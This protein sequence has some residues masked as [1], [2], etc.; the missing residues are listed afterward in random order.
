MKL[1][2]TQSA[3]DDLAVLQAD[4]S[5]KRVLKDVLKALGLMEVN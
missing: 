5:K 2:F 4:H 3:K 1:R